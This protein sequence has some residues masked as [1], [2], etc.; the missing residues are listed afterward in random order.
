MEY[1]KRD[2]MSLPR[3]A[4]LVV[5]SIL[6]TLSCLLALLALMKLLPCW[7]GVHGKVYLA[8]SR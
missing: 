2:E 3:L 4:Y 6:L 1:S 8:A 5:T 7:R